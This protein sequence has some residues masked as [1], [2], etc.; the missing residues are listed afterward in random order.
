MRFSV[1]ETR[2]NTSKLLGDE[3]DNVKFVLISPDLRLFNKKFM[4][5][6]SPLN[7]AIPEGTWTA[8][9]EMKRHSVSVGENVAPPRQV[10]GSGQGARTTYNGNTSKGTAFKM[11]FNKT[12]IAQIHK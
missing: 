10:S 9:G 12:K 3:N 11:T 1:M 5:F 8:F 2:Q 7:S 6:L 4:K